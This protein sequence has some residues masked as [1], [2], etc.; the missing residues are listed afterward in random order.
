M[1][2]VGLNAESGPLQ[3]ICGYLQQG[4]NRKNDGQ[5]AETNPRDFKETNNRNGQNV[6]IFV[7]IVDGTRCYRALVHGRRWPQ[8]FGKY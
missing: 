5:R 1:T 8:T 7:A 4:P 2:P 6:M 3:N